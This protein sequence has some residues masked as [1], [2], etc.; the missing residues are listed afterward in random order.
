MCAQCTHIHPSKFSTGVCG[1]KRLKNFPGIFSHPFYICHLFHTK[2]GGEEEE[3]E[4]D[5]DAAV[6]F[7]LEAARRSHGAEGFSQSASSLYFTQSGLFV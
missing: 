2:G 4:N 6:V 7:N 3:S 1:R 5:V